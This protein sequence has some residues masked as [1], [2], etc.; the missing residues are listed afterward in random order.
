MTIDDDE[1]VELRGDGHGDDTRALLA[2]LRRNSPGRAVL[3]P[4]RFLTTGLSLRGLSC[5]ITGCDDAT[6]I[7]ALPGQSGPDRK[8]VV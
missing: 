6:V 5:S 1:A 3:P 2:L 7:A 8:S 4:G